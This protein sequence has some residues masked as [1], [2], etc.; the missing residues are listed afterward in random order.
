[1]PGEGRGISARIESPSRRVAAPAWRTPPFAATTAPAADTLGGPPPSRGPSVRIGVAGAALRESFV[2]LVAFALAGR[3]WARCALP[4]LVT[5][6]LWLARRPSATAKSGAGAVDGRTTGYVADAG[7]LLRRAP[8]SVAM[9]GALLD[10]RLTPYNGRWCNGE[11]G[12]G[13]LPAG[14][15]PVACRVAAGTSDRG[16]VPR[17][18]ALRIEGSRPGSLSA[19][20]G[21]RSSLGDGRR[22][23]GAP[24][25]DPAL[26]ELP[27]LGELGWAMGERGASKVALP[28]SLLPVDDG[29][30]ASAGAVSMTA[31]PLR[32]SGEFR[33][34]STPSAATPLLRPPMATTAF[35][36]ALSDEPDLDRKPRNDALAGLV[37]G[38]AVELDGAAPP[39]PRVLP[40]YTPR[41]AA[42]R[43]RAAFCRCARFPDWSPPSLPPTRQVA[44]GGVARAGAA[45]TGAA[46]MGVSPIGVA[47]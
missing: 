22:L 31:A 6:A 27:P 30:S 29:H 47:R 44:P 24:A 2:A 40:L 46:R 13:E 23:S 45:R 19:S 14:D 7:R 25:S 39:A 28:R 32:R 8:G 18:A 10:A 36:Y 43:G 16:G 34:V 38:D 4:L 3:P 1:M 15:A 17:C 37:A 11:C 41:L 42:G 33:R 20:T 12:T 26:P 21:G 5:S 35:V 9:W